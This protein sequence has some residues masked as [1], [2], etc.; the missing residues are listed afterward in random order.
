MTTTTTRPSFQLPVPPRRRPR[1]EPGI[2]AGSIAGIEIRVDLSVLFIALLVTFQLTGW[3][4][5]WHPEWGPL[6]GVLAVVSAALLIG[7]ILVHELSHAFVGRYLGLP[8]ERVTLF[9]FGGMAELGREPDQPKVE[10]LTALAGPVASLVLGAVSVVSGLMLAGPLP[11]TPAELGDFRHFGAVSTVLLWLGPANLMLGLFNLVPGFPLDGG[12]VVRAVIWW[13]TGDLE[14]ATRSA[15]RGGQVVAALLVVAGMLMIFG[16]RLPF[17]GVGV[18]SGLWLILM[19]WFL[20]L[21]AVRS[22]EEQTAHEGLGGVSVGM[23]MLLRFESIPSNTSMAELER[24]FLHSDQRCFPVVDGSVPVGLVC[25]GD[26]RRVAT[27]MSGDAP[28]TTIMTPWRDLVVLSPST[29]ASHALRKLALLDVDQLP[30]MDRERLVGFVRR[31]DI[32]K[33]L[34]LRSEQPRATQLDV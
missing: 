18:A 15:V 30:V 27:T 6:V 32:L 3:F 20:N 17:F 13:R 10:L 5:A 12:R 25:L 14:Q 29:P 22:L 4:A 19:G 1:A 33:W 21:A 34:A 11:G 9:I 2:R 24:S 31:R 8:V 16:Y 7:S 28:V 23:L 26:L